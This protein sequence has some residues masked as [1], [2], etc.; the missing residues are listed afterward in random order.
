[1]TH[2]NSPDLEEEGKDLV[3]KCVKTLEIPRIEMISVRTNVQGTIGIKMQ[4]ADGET[5]R[6]KINGKF[7][8]REGNRK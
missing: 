7:N 3:Q 8:T 4:S 6:F 5:K 2:K 1:M